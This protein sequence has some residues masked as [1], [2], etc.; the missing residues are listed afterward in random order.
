MKTKTDPRLTGKT[1]SNVQAR[2]ISEYD[3][4][5]CQWITLHT[6]ANWGTWRKFVT[7]RIATFGGP[8]AGLHPYHVY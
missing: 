8:I 2:C 5:D 4:G 7:F 1:G 3:H 6:M